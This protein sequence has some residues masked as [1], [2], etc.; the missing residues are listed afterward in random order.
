MK[1]FII[2]LISFL[3][4]SISGCCTKV[5]C[6]GE[7]AKLE[8]RFK[9]SQKEINIVHYI[10]DELITTNNYAFL[11]DTSISFAI[12]NNPN[13]KDRFQIL[14]KDSLYVLNNFNVKVTDIYEVEC[15]KCFLADGNEKIEHLEVTE[16]QENSQTLNQNYYEIKY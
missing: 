8:F 6:K 16:F 15:N 5:D 2:I 11:K 10:N 1:V 4:V 7:D 13:H 12:S 3:L 14:I 9:N